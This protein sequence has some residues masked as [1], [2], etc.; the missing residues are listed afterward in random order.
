MKKRS[1]LTILYVVVLIL[2]I[3]LIGMQFTD[4]IQWG[5]VDFLVAAILIFGAGIALDLI[6]RKVRKTQYRVLISVALILVVLLI[7]AELAVG[8]F[9]TPLSGN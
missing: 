8:I 6:I 2:L 1:I 5:P 4:A 9:G 7:W 3:P